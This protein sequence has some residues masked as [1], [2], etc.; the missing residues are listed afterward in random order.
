MISRL[1]SPETRAFEVSVHPLL[2]LHLDSLS[3]HPI[4][5]STRS[6]PSPNTHLR[7]RFEVD[8]GFAKSHNT[9]GATS[10]QSP[11]D[12]LATT[13]SPTSLP[14][15]IVVL[16]GALSR[17]PHHHPTFLCTRLFLNDTTRHLPQELTLTFTRTPSALRTRHASDPIGTQIALL[18]DTSIFASGARGAHA[19]PTSP[20][21]GLRSKI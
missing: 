13:F 3:L 1:Q 17:Q 14:R 12:Y 5:Q 9:L 21:R 15:R 8:V 4:H 16:P 2:L 19:H 6:R 18:P 7:L 10:H 11:T 20:C